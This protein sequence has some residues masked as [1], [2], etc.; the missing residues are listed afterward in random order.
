MI[1]S[2]V[3]VISDQEK[4]IR[5]F[6]IQ[7]ENVGEENLKLANANEDLERKVNDLEKKLGNVKVDKEI[8]SNENKTV[9]DEIVNVKIENK[10]EA[11]NN[12]T[13]VLKPKQDAVREP[14]KPILNFENFGEAF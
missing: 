8:D 13:K 11:L 5:K 14:T 12:K 9:L 10:F 1:D 7:N 2:K 6:K 4:T 3:R